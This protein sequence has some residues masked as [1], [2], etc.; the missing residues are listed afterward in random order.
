MRIRTAALSLTTALV[1]ALALTACSTTETSTP[2]SS[3]ASCSAT[4]LKVAVTTNVWASIVDQL[5][6]PCAEIST[7]I[8]SPTADPHDFEPTSATSATFAQSQLVVVNGLGYDAWATK[9]VDSLGNSAPATLNLGQAVG[10]KVGDNP[11]I[12][13]SPQYV[14]EAAAA[15]T[16]QLQSSLPAA[17]AQFTELAGT[18]ATNLKP[19]LDQVANIK[20]KYAG[21]KIGSTES[22]FVYMAE[23]TGLN[24]TTP[25]GFMTAIATDSDPST[26]DVATFRQQITS[27]TDKVLVYN[28]QT[29]G[30]LPTQMR[31]L[32]Q[33]NGVPIVNITE[34]LVPEGATFQAWQQAQL[35]E[36]WNALGG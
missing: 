6:G 16:K 10:L 27:K 9:I 3:S 23:A 30:G 1:G 29:E 34:T 18:F 14:Q 28:T 7:I 22:V 17:S 19:Y 26:Q 33:T 5:S 36:L 24:I 32:A 8:T 11:H 31:D 25:P 21:T 12:W 2:A 15:I 4:P 13:Y 20:A 35:T